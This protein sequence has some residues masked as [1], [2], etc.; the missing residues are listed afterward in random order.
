MMAALAAR[1]RERN[2]VAETTCLP[3]R[4]PQRLFWIWSSMWKPATPARMYCETELAIMMGPGG[5][6]DG[7][8]RDEIECNGVGKGIKVGGCIP[9]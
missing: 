3:W 1:M 6:L 2:S 4:W 9:P 8:V 7:E 5:L